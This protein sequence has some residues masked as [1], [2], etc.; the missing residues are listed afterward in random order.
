[1]QKRI[2]KTGRSPLVVCVLTVAFCVALCLQSDAGDATEEIESV[3]CVD[4]SR[5]MGDWYEIARYLSFF[6][7]NCVAVRSQ[8]ELR[9]D[10]KI[11]IINYY[12]KKKFDAPQETAKS[13]AWF[14]DQD[15]NA[16]LKVQ[17]FCRSLRDTGSS[18]WTRITSMLSSAIPSVTASGS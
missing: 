11:T 18:I 8:C 15:T 4:V 14:T 13:R 3:P 16:K 5:F 2:V 9:K 12:K 7:K 1:M 6:E 17:F 10:G